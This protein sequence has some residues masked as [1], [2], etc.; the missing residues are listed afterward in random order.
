MVDEVITT[1]V[2]PT[3]RGLIPT[4]A[5]EVVVENGVAFGLEGDARESTDVKWNWKSSTWSPPGKKL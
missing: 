2:H 4:V 3:A 5:R 1:V